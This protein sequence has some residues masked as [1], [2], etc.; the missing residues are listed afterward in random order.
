MRLGE[1]FLR[2][3]HSMDF[4]RNTAYKVWHDLW[5][6]RLKHSLSASNFKAKIALVYKWKAL[7][8]TYVK[9]CS[10]WITYMYISDR[11]FIAHKWQ[12]MRAFLSSA[13]F[14][15][16]NLEFFRNTINVSN[17]WMLCSKVC[18]HVC[19]ISRI[20]DNWAVTWDFR[21]SSKGS[22][23]PAH[24]RSQIRAFVSRLTILWLRYWPKLE[25]SRL[26]WVCTC[27]NTTLL[28][29]IA[30]C[31]S[32]VVVNFGL[33]LWPWHRMSENLS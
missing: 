24:M 23:Q 20:G 21:A 29:E 22:D 15:S 33:S 13:F 1:A 8:C 27:Q 4:Y 32:Y 31:S 6:L 5:R 19:I 14:F 3:A 16:N 17:I 28:E 2:S 18:W 9:K 30:R 10:D 12:I 26:I 7:S 25:L 11:V